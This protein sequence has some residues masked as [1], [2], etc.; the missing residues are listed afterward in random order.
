MRLKRGL[1][2]GAS[3]TLQDA[4]DDASKQRLTNSP[5]HLAN[6]RF[7][8]PGPIARSLA[9]VEWR[10]LGTRATVTGRTG[11]PMSIGAVNRSLPI[12]REPTPGVNVRNLFNAR[13][14]DPASGAHTTDAIQHNGRSLRVGLGWTFWRAT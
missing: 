9:S 12:G 8:G 2:G 13:D 14:A 5:R 1:Q 6:L 4:V 3:Y 11:S 7:S 10:D